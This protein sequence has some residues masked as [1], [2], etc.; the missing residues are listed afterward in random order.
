[1]QGYVDKKKSA[2]WNMAALAPA[3]DLDCTAGE[4]LDYLRNMSQPTKQ[5]AQRIARLE[6]PTK[7]INERLQIG[8]GWHLMEEK[9]KPT[10]Y[11]HNGG[12]YGF[13]TFAAYIKGTGQA[14]VVVVNKANANKASDALG[15][16]IL[17]RMAAE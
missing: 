1:S 11:W 3:G 15:I 8:L 4:M 13:S 14:V 5:T 17:R 7:R 16:A 2:Y 6:T 12:T 9:G 10:L